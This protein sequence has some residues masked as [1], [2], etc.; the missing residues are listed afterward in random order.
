M[1]VLEADV[2]IRLGRF[3]REAGI[4]ATSVGEGLTVLERAGAEIVVTTPDE[5]DVGALAQ[6]RL[7]R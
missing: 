1:D 3:A 6:G 2:A 4:A 5:I 7:A